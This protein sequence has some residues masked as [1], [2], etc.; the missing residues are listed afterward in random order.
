[1]SANCLS[2]KKGTINENQP[3]G[4]PFYFAFIYFIL[5]IEVHSEFVVEF[6]WHHRLQEDF[7]LNVGTGFVFSLASVPNVFAS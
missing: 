1:M 4:F 5:G 7:H 3:L 2:C 6:S